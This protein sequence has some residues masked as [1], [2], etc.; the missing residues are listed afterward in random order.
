M[1]SRPMCGEYEV[2]CSCDAPNYGNAKDAADPWQSGKLTSVCFREHEV[3]KA[4]HSLESMPFGVIT[5][6]GNRALKKVRKMFPKECELVEAELVKCSYHRAR[7]P[8]VT[9]T[10]VRHPTLDFGDPWP[11]VTPSHCSK[12]FEAALRLGL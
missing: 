12:F 3:H 4:K 8:G 2:N 5:A 7:Y 1:S 10:W 11:C 6:R 9:Y